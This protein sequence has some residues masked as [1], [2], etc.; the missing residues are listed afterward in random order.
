MDTSTKSRMMKIAEDMEKNALGLDNSFQFKCSACGKCCKNRHDILLT[1]RD[2]YNIARSL[3]RTT[4]YV[5]E[6]YC[7][8]YIGD[9]SRFPIVRLKPSGPE[10]VCPMLRDKRCIV[11]KEKP[12]VCAMFPL[13]RGT[14][15]DGDEYASGTLKK[16]MPIYFLPKVSCGRRDQTHTVREWLEQSGIPVEDEFYSLWTGITTELAVLF[17]E[18]ESRKATERTMELLWSAA[19]SELYHNYDVEAEFMPQYRDHAAKLRDLLTI[20]KNEAEKHLGG[21]RD[22]K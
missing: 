12:V 16:M 17:S 19:Y 3:G 14:M 11:H 22:G 10:A 5:V 18:L 2:L 1:P 21:L 6:R 7:E 9:S 13:G 4:E 20:I 8:V 15:M